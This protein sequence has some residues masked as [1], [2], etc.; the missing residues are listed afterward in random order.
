MQAWK[1]H[2]PGTAM[3][4]TEYVDDIVTGGS[5]AECFFH[6]HSRPVGCGIALLFCVALIDIITLAPCCCA[7]FLHV[8]ARIINCKST[9]TDW[10]NG[11]W[12]NNLGGFVCILADFKM[13][14]GWK[15]PAKSGNTTCVCLPQLNRVCACV[16]VYMCLCILTDVHLSH[17]T[18]LHAQMEKMYRVLH[19]IFI[20]HIHT[21]VK[22]PFLEQNNTWQLLKLSS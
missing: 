5:H 22:A 11:Y 14:L 9:L 13:F 16:H 12:P 19:C 3:A 4:K 6:P 1:W 20:L 7:M 17:C 21:A 2:S 15:P 8:V 10:W 18:S